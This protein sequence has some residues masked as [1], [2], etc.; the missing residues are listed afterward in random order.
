MWNSVFAPG[1]SDVV[2]ARTVPCAERGEWN[3]EL[4]FDGYRSQIV[5]DA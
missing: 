4:K 2:D 5:R 1:M 3:H